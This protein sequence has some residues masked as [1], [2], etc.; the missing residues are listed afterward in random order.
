MSIRDEL[1]V[2]KKERNKILSRATNFTNEEKAKLD[3]MN[4]KI[5]KLEFFLDV[6]ET[7]DND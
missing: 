2:L 4:K 7:T 6:N 5:S 1:N 3:N